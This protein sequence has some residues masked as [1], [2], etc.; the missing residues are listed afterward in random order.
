MIVGFALVEIYNEQAGFLISVPFRCTQNELD[1]SCI[2]ASHENDSAQHLITE[3]KSSSHLGKGGKERSWGNGKLTFPMLRA[4]RFILNPSA[5]KLGRYRGQLL[6]LKNLE[7][8]TVGFSFPRYILAINSPSYSLK[9]GH[10]S[11]L[12]GRINHK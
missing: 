6:G 2:I 8:C 7:T 5:A 3:Q 1:I 11:C 10:V 9:A 4:R 12:Y